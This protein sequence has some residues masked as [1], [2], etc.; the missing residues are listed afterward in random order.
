[1]NVSEKSDGLLAASIES[2]LVLAPFRQAR[3]ECIPLLVMY[4]ET[5][6]IT[7]ELKELTKGIT[8]RYRPFVYNDGVSLEEKS[9]NTFQ[10]ISLPGIHRFCNRIA[11][12]PYS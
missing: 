8:R 11:H 5:A 1:M 2:P 9:G 3:Q 12:F 6:I 4:L 10:P 7:N